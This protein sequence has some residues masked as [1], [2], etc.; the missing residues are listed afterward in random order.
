MSQKRDQVG[1]FQ[2]ETLLDAAQLDIKIAL[3]SLEGHFLAGI[4]R[5]EIDFTK[6]SNSNA[7][8]DRVSVQRGCAGCIVKLH[9]AGGWLLWPIEGLVPRF[10]FA[11]VVVFVNCCGWLLHLD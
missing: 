3:N 5:G 9:R 7:A 4:A 1:V 6:S 11:R 8:F 10:F 2:I